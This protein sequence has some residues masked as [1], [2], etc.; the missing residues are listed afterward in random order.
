MS[1][2]RARKTNTRAPTRNQ[3]RRSFGTHWNVDGRWSGDSYGY[4]PHGVI[5]KPMIYTDHHHVDGHCQAQVMTDPTSEIRPWSQ[6]RDASIS[7][8]SNPNPRPFSG[9]LVTVY[10]DGEWVGPDGPWRSQMRKDM[11]SVF[12]QI[13]KLKREKQLKD[14]QARVAQEA[15][16]KQEFKDAAKAFC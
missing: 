9:K 6:G 7:N 10:R 12:W 1:E 8:G 4:H 3:F 14:E 5:M 13:R 11:A 15:A 2:Q 16:A